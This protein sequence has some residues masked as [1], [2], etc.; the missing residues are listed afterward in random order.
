LQIDHLSWRHFLKTQVLIIGGGATG[1]GLARDLALRGIHCIMAEKRDINA[2]ASGGN[3]GLLHSGARYI[4]SDPSAAVECQREG[5]LLKKLA[6]H[7]I[8]DTGGLFVAVAGDDE[9]YIADFSH[10]CAKYG[11]PAYVMD[12]KDALEIEPALSDQII[13]VFR[14]EDATIDPFRLSLA[15]IAHAQQLG[16]RLLR[17]TQTVDF[18][19]VNGKIRS[20]LLLDRT[21]GKKI[22][23]EP[24]IVVNASGAWAGEVAALAGVHIPMRYSKGSMLVTNTRITQRVVN[25]LRCPA[26]G[27]I[28]AP[29]G[30]VSILGTTSERVKSPDLYY[31]EIHE[32]DQI[33]EQGA[34]MLPILASAHYVRAFSGVRALFGSEDMSDDRN[35][36]RGFTLI[37]H[38]H[39]SEQI[40]NFVTITGGKLTTYRLMAEKT[41][42]LVCKHLGITQ[43]C[44]THI[45]PL[46][47]TADS[48]WTKPG[49]APR[50]WIQKKNPKDQLLCECQMV[51]QS[52][53][54]SVTSSICKQNGT[55]SLNA[56]GLRSRV[57]K[58]SCQ[59]MFCSLRVSSYLYDRKEFSDTQG[60][61]DLCEFLSERWRGLHSL[62]WDL[63]LI[64][65]ELMEAL[66]CGLFGLELT[67]TGRR[68]NLS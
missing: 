3:Q 55:P 48:K 23:I 36:S 20:V 9:N 58:G 31:P 15:N 16:A 13:A 1:T 35:V 60:L 53:I 51:P 45:E 38:S 12:I 41:G 68:E 43:P 22:S 67:C 11:I 50:L 66:H 4:A 63:P 62:Q 39:G 21:S 59:G 26:N 10:R 14:V 42:D 5:R 24:E 54:D 25:R 61:Q 65:F 27:D 2:G 6:A 44:Q 46:P 28:L 18:K 40:E 30:T 56:I 64:K 37:D 29:G 8:E 17:F 34:A 7:C 57:G 52:A 19:I 32:I 49:L 33:I 47:Q